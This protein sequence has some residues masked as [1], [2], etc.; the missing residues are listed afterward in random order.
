M[1]LQFNNYL[2]CFLKDTLLPCRISG[3]ASP[4][5]GV[6]PR[7]GCSSQRNKST[8]IHLPKLWECWAEAAEPD[9]QADK[10]IQLPLL[11]HHTLI[12]AVGTTLFSAAVMGSDS[13]LWFVKKSRWHSTAA[14]GCQK[15]CF[16]VGCFSPTR[17]L[18][19]CC[20]SSGSADRDPGRETPGGG[21]QEG[22]ASSAL[23]LSQINPAE[24][25]PGGAV[26]HNE[27]HG[28]SH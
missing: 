12:P 4:A 26:L 10:C 13:G 19:C 18:E 1:N 22:E 15:I 23:A 5:T 17:W 28:S 25:S 16:W 14:K 2:F 24:L 27:F 8:S 21:W 6:W 9:S 3:C 11:P 7:E 20:W